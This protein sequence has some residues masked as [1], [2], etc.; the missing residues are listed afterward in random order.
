[1]LEYNITNYNTVINKGWAFGSNGV[2]HI[3]WVGMSALLSIQLPTNAYPGRQQV[4][5]QLLG[6]P[7]IL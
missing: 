7:A 5:V 3:P 4:T 2:T 1:M 6:I